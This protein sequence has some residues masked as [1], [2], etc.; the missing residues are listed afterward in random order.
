MLNPQTKYPQQAWE[1]MNYM[2][3]ASAQTALSKVEVRISPRDDVNAATL[4]NDPLLT[5][6]SK[7]ILPITSFRPSDANYNAVSVAIQQATADVVGGKS[8]TSAAKTYQSTL[9]KAVGD[10]HVE[11]G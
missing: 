6:I 2:V 5:F 3:S 10:A 8:A 11:T 9:Q 4:A 7:T 1:L